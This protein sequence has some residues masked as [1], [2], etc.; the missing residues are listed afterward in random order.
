[1]FEVIRSFFLDGATF[2]RTVSDVT[3]AVGIVAT[4]PPAQAALTGLAP[5]AGWLGPALVLLGGFAS[6]RQRQNAAP[7]Q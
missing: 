4:S 1:M 5:G 7:P 6:A 3:T 2:K